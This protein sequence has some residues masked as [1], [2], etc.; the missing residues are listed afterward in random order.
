MRELEEQRQ[1]MADEAAQAQQEAKTREDQ[2]S[3]RM[4][5]LFDHMATLQQTVADN[6]RKA[7]QRMIKLEEE[8]RKQQ[9]ESAAATLAATQKMDAQFQQLLLLGVEF[10]G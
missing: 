9:A 10:A 6:Q 1:S 8:N 4:D 3:N 2:H 7:E 5:K